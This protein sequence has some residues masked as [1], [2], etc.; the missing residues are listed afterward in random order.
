[1]QENKSGLFFE[2]SVHIT[3]WVECMGSVGE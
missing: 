3:Q 2:H 1:M